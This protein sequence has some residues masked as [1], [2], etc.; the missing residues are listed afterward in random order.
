MS[1][2]LCGHYSVKLRS[3]L[4]GIP[5]SSFLVCLLLF[6]F[7]EKKVL[8]W[9]GN[10]AKQEC[11]LCLYSARFLSEYS[12]NEYHLYEHAMGMLLGVTGQTKSLRCIKG[13][14]R[15]HSGHISYLNSYMPEA[16]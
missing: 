1:P 12:K 2:L 9:F 10:L 8:L 3:S 5:T 4:K 6:L 7:R 16:P 13:E 14:S 15:A 11:I